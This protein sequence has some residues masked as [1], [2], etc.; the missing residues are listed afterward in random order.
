MLPSAGL[1]DQ[2]PFAHAPSQ[3]RLA[4]SIVDLVRAGVAQVFPLQIDLR[5]TEPPR[6]VPRSFGGGDTTV[7]GYLT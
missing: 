5:P 3:Q 2:P 4:N 6:Q 1:G 7:K